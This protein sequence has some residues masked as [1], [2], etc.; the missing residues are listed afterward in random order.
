MDMHNLQKLETQHFI[1]DA[2]LTKVELIRTV[3]A[4]GL[5]ACVIQ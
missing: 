2:L 3:Q 1:F 4:A 5:P